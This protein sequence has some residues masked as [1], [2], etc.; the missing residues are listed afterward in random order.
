[1]CAHTNTVTWH[2]NTGSQH[3]ESKE[4][5][6]LP[7]STPH[8][9]LLRLELCRDCGITFGNDKKS[10]KRRTPAT[11]RLLRKKLNKGKAKL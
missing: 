5:H 2:P 7:I 9:P 4:G 11:T 6:P 3:D 8:G 1:M 10:R